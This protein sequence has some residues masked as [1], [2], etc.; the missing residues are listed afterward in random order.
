MK[1]NIVGIL[2]AALLWLTAM[3]AGGAAPAIAATQDAAPRLRVALLLDQAP[4]D[5]GPTDNVLRG[6]QRAAQELGVLTEVIN[7]PS[8]AQSEPSKDETN[9]NVTGKNAT[10]MSAAQQDALLDA[11]E[12]GFKRAASSYDLVVVNSPALHELL[13]NHAGNFRRTRFI[14]V[15]GTVKAPN[16]ASITFADTQAA[17][18]AGAAAATLTTHSTIPGM[19]AERILGWVG[20]FDTPSRRAEAEAFLLGARLVHPETRVITLFTEDNHEESGHR[21]AKELYAKGADIIAHH[22][23]KAGLGI[24]R[25][26]AEQQ[27]YAIG[28]TQDQASVQG[29]NAAVLFSQLHNSD[30]AVFDSIKAAVEGRFPGGTEEVRGLAS[31]GKTEGQKS[32]VGLTSLEPLRQR[33]GAAFPTGLPQRLQELQFEIERGAII[34]PKAQKKSLCDCL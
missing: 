27:R 12:Q 1:T 3:S 22:A 17:F 15:D 30:A 4:G 34:L 23:G 10:D 21:A 18:L 32:G 20:D 11:Q 16:I 9:K 14:A 33:F 24:L 13:M 5:H 31:Q 25:A 7:L 2:G 8:T 29:G 19:N 26:A 6:L 28:H